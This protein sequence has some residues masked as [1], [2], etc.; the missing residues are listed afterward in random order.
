MKRSRTWVPVL[1]GVLAF[2]LTT[3]TLGAVVADWTLR[4]Q[5]MDAFVTAVEQSEAQMT[6]TQE[7]VGLIFDELEDP[8]QATENSQLTLEL[9]GIAAE[10][11]DRIK[12]A[13][14]QVAAV[15]ISPWHQDL[16]L[17]KQ[18]YLE[19]NQAWQAYLDRA[20]KDAV[21]FTLPQDEVN[22]TFLEAEPLFRAAIP[23]PDGFSL[24][25]RVD[26]IFAE[27][28]PE[29]GPTQEAHLAS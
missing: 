10:G 9:Q 21:E 20:A 26:L 1:L 24:A 19:H 27:P 12:A 23:V 25:D 28:E 2:L 14:D 16:L 6:W 15:R 5:E 8:A 22:S 7:S 4:N 13:G 17:A 29:G 3:V 18:A 11:R